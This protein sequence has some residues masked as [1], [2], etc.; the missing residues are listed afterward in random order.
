MRESGFTAVV[1]CDPFRTAFGPVSL[2]RATKPM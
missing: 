2:Y 1:E